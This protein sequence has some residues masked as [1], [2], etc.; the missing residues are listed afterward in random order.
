MESKLSYL[1]AQ[2][3]KEE[4]KMAE[5]DVIPPA[6]MPKEMIDLEAALDKMESEL[7]EINSNAL[8]LF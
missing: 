3:T 8:V 1:E 6:P 4:V 2:I 5:L 7:K